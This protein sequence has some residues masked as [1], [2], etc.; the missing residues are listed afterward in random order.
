MPGGGLRGSV[1][2]LGSLIERLDPAAAPAHLEA[3]S[4]RLREGAES[5]RSVKQD[6]LVQLLAASLRGGEVRVTSPLDE[7]E[8][9]L[10]RDHVSR[11]AANTGGAIETAPES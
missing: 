11:R 7:M 2:S 3:L 9:G 1:Q 5:D 8:L 10:V 6:R 4:Q